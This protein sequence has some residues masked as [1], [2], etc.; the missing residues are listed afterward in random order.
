MTSLKIPNS[1]RDVLPDRRCKLEIEKYGLRESPSGPA[2]YQGHAEALSKLGSLCN[3]ESVSSGQRTAIGTRGLFT[4]SS[5]GSPI[6]ALES[7]ARNAH[8]C[9]TRQLFV[10]WERFPLNVARQQHLPRTAVC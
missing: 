5:S 7:E 10:Y 3:F 4:C 1:Y 9:P 8:H 6:S 2:A